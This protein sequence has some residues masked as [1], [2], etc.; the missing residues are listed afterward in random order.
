MSQKTRNHQKQLWLHPL[1]MAGANTLLTY[2]MPFFG[3]AL[4]S[5]IPV[6][7]PEWLLTSPIGLFKSL[8]FA[9]ICAEVAGRLGRLWVQLKL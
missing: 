6:S 3:Y 9:L 5:L 2:L 1:R 4:F 7:L 8:I